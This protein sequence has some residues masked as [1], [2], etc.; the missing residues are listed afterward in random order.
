MQ[1]SDGGPNID[2]RLVVDPSFLELVRLG[3][4]PAGDQVIRN[5]IAVVDS[6]LSYLTTN[7]RFWHRASFDGYGEQRDGN[8]WEP[9][10]PGSGKTL[11]RGWPLLSGERGEYSLVAG[12]LA[13]AKHRLARW[14]V[15]PT[16]GAS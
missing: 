6:K 8:Q 12:R 11:G 2:Q 13:A 3:V 4:K 9:S 16:P 5:S 10:D 14:L 7:G 1:V 15:P